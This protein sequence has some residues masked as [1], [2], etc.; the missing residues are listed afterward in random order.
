MRHPRGVQVALLD[1][2]PISPPYPPP[3]ALEAWGWVWDQVQIGFLEGRAYAGEPGWGLE[4]R[5]V[6]NA[7]A[8]LVL[9]GRSVWRIGDRSVAAGPGDLLLIPE[10]VPHA[11]EP[12]PAPVH[13]LSVH[14]TAR[15]LG[16]QCLLLVLGFPVVLKDRA[17]ADV[18]QELVRLTTH[19]PPGWRQRGR[20]LI[21]ELLLRTVHERPADFRPMQ[22]QEVRALRLL[23]HVFQLLEGTDGGMRVAELA[24][25]AACSPTH[26]R[27]LFRTAL[28]MSP[29]RYLLERRLQRAAELLRGTDHTVQQ[30]AERCGFESLSHFHRH[31]KARY[32]CTPLAFRTRLTQPP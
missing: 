14:F 30:V 23:C 12:S 31:F 29:S 19:E 2:T 27:R 28:G 13:L 5:T 16:T 7:L 20:A 11:A 21:T 4:R 9:E 18:I 22:V 15:V 10:G 17:S 26:L 24:R 25:A 32:G 6:P 1:R 8:V 3:G